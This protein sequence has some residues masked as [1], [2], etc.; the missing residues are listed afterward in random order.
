MPCRQNNINRVNSI[1]YS[2]IFKILYGV[3]YLQK[4]LVL[5]KPDAVERNLIGKILTYYEENDLKIIALRMEKVT[6]DFAIRHYKEHEGKSFFKPLI[7][8]ITRSPLCALVLEGNDAVKK[9]REINGSTNPANQKEGTIR[10][11]Y[12]I[13]VTENAVHSSDS[14]KRAQE[15]IKLWF[16]DL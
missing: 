9:V 1:F 2:S 16:P 6:R 14:V 4:T 13:S 8:Y 10:K 15:E 5:I 11:A 3:R 12:A 7:D